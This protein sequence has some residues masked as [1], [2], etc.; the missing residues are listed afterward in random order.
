MFRTTQNCLMI[1]PKERFISLHN[2]FV[3][4][5]LDI[6]IIN[7]QNIIVEIKQNFRPF[8]LW[9]STQKGKYCLELAYQSI[10]NV[11][12]KVEIAYG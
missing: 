11:G 10:Y 4:Y 9:S 2:F 6:L 3:F 1:F 8:T 5:P 7:E 12:D